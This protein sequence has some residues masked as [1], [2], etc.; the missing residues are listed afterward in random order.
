MIGKSTNLTIVV[1]REA[2]GRYYCRA[3]VPGFTDISAEAYVRMNS[4]PSIQKNGIQYGMLGDSVRLECSAYSV[5]LPEKTVWSF[6]GQE[7]GPNH[8]DYSVSSR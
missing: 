4:R 2:T 7:I 8:Q 1:S 6:N 3:H 5:P